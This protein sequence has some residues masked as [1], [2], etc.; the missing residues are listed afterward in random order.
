MF[1]KIVSNLPFSPN[2]IGQF[3]LYIKNTRREKIIRRLGLIFTFLAL[4]LQLITV[5][6]PPEPANIKHPN[7][8][9]EGVN[10]S[11]DATINDFLKLY[12]INHNNIRDILDFAGIT[13]QEVANSQYSSWQQK[14]KFIWGFISLLGAEQGEK[15]VDITTNQGEAVRRIFIR[16][17]IDQP[18]N[19]LT[20]NRQ[21]LVGSSQKA[22]WFAI[23]QYGGNLVTEKVPDQSILTSNAIFT[24]T[25]INTSQG[26]VD[27]STVVARAND[28]V[29]YI[30]TVENNGSSINTI[31]LNDNLYDVL[32][33]ATLIDRG[34][35]ILNND[36]SYLTWPD[37]T[38]EPGA[39][40][41]RTFVI[42][43]DNPV[44]ATPRG[45]SEPASYDCVMTNVFG[46]AININIACPPQK[47]VEQAASS[48]P[49][50]SPTNNILFASVLFIV[51]T[52]L[53]IR[54]HQLSK[55]LHIIRRN[56]Y[57]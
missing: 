35:G 31:Q 18:A 53:Y 23:T 57:E 37:V 10:L 24:K 16:P 50:T 42:K 15:F 47:L 54:S 48:F 43:I 32:E 13:R 41:T 20:V 3:N 39:K 29:R 34:G 36:S 26:L 56:M 44:Y 51:V 8:F 55:E 9:I 19:R 21:G 4:S 52:F 14:N 17:Y 40:Q 12:D 22:G 30:I 27:A 1:K 49:E 38:L 46:S 33:Y 5:F 2:L 11:S 7:D 28:Q 6:H 25:A 45:V